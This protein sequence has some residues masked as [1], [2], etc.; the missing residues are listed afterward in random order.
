M[1]TSLPI[2]VSW[3][4][5]LYALSYLNQLCRQCNCPFVSKEK[6]RLGPFCLLYQMPELDVT[7]SLLVAE[8]SEHLCI[9]FII[10]ISTYAP[11]Y[12]ILVCVFVFGLLV[13]GF[14]F[15]VFLNF[16]F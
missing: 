12:V 1:L 11:F 9:S 10:R 7:T 6:S 5:T 8:I 16:C 2:C 4:C 14:L 13:F 15:F 3:L